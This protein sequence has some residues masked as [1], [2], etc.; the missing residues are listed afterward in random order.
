M[1][2]YLE[3]GQGSAP[4][5]NGAF[6]NMVP[7]QT[8]IADQPHMLAY[9]NPA[10]EQMLRD[11]GGAGMPGPDGVPAYYHA[12]G[13]AAAKDLRYDS[14]D[15]QL[16]AENP[17]ITYD[18]YGLNPSSFVGSNDNDT[19][20]QAAKQAAIRQQG[21]KNSGSFDAAGVEIIPE[22][23][24]NTPSSTG[25]FETQER[26][27]IANPE[28]YN[29]INSNNGNSFM[30]GLA[31]S[32]TPYD[33]ASYVNGR[34]VDD[35]TGDFL[36]ANSTSY[37]GRSIRG[38]SNDPSNDSNTVPESFLN[39]L[40]PIVTNPFADT[41]TETQTDNKWGYTTQDGRVVTASQ[42][43]MD[44]GG[45]N[46]G[47]E[48]FGISGGKNVDLN[49]D[50]YITREEAQASGGLNENFVS[51][52]SNA[53][54]ATP[55]GSGLDPTGIAGVLNTPIIGSM[56]TGGLSGL[57]TGAR[58][59]TNN[60]GYKDRPESS[61]GGDMES[62]LSG[63][64]GQNRINAE[65]NADRALLDYAADTPNRRDGGDGTPNITT[66]GGADDDPATSGAVREDIMGAE[67]GD[68][69]RKYKGG[70]GAYLPA[71]MQRYMSGETIDDMFRQFTGEDGKQYYITPTGEIYD[72]DA[73]IGAATG[74]TSRLETGN[75]IV[76]GYTETDASGN[77]TS[78]NNDGTPL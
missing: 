4:R 19:A 11:M 44:G 7:R 72:A 71:Y 63:L 21:F 14:I 66:S 36:S 61:L 3:G 53:S 38:N 73:F 68:Y 46:F 33:G 39:S 15:D 26:D 40:P 10:E 54:G 16:R 62:T 43:K 77:V 23:D 59:L 17:V 35:R 37:A 18:Q 76:V 41:Y 13:H 65:I 27:Q 57:Y 52:F 9:I 45:K 32:F 24:G 78:Y 49:G 6:A 47:G 20:Y 70:S 29:T 12:T 55:L 8:I 2:D 25:Y 56:L 69:I 51:S 74:D 1:N 67:M 50:G 30:E 28:K 42:D 75:E 31:N 22:K 48:V 5:Q 64:T 58:Y 34:L 60:F